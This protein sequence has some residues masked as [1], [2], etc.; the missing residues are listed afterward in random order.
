MTSY[1]LPPPPANFSFPPDND[2]QLQFNYLDSFVTSWVTPESSEDPA[3]LSL[4]YWNSS[5][6]KE[7]WTSS[8]FAPIYI[9]SVALNAIE[10]VS[11]S[12]H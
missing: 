7:P 2:E 10:I 4:Y 1:Q 5:T 12:I 8:M 9:P 6:P 3:F 11:E